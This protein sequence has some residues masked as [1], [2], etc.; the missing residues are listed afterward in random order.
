M[1]RSA[2]GKLLPVS[3]GMTLLVLMLSAVLYVALADDERHHWHEWRYLYSAAHYTEL[4]LR[5]GTFDPG[6]PPE[7][8]ADE[9]GAWYW[10]QML[11]LTVLR[12]VVQVFGLGETEY[13][14]C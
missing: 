9:I 7:R 5:L 10:G 2:R 12:S 1:P 14:G 3:G 8:S 13:L 4:E 6:P 11:H